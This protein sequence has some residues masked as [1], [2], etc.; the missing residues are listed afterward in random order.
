MPSRLIILST[1]NDIAHAAARLLDA[2]ADGIAV[3][4]PPVTAKPG[5]QSACASGGLL[6]AVHF[7]AY[8]STAE[9]V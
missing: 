6:P 8:L 5:A 4:H 9:N 1:W 3:M 7:T 2:S